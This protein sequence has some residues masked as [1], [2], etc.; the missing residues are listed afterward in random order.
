[1][2]SSWKPREDDHVVVVQSMNLRH[3]LDFGS[4]SC[5]REGD[6]IQSCFATESDV[7]ALH[8]IMTY[9]RDRYSHLIV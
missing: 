3:R 4:R 2:N 6:H 1:M 5:V 9:D 8:T 7:G